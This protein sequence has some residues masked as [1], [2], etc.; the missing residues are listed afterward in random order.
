MCKWKLVIVHRSY[1]LHGGGGHR[2]SGL[3]C[4]TPVKSFNWQSSHDIISG[5]S[6]CV[7]MINDV[8]RH[9]TPIILKRVTRWHVTCLQHVTSPQWV[10]WVQPVTWLQHGTWQF[11]REKDRIL[12]IGDVLLEDVTLPTALGLLRSCGSVAELIIRRR[13]YV[14][15]PHSRQCKSVEINQTR[16]GRQGKTTPRFLYRVSHI[17]RSLAQTPQRWLSI[18]DG[19]KRA[20]AVIMSWCVN[21]E[22]TREK[23]QERLKSDLGLQFLA[24][25]QEKTTNRRKG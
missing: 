24:D 25:Q 18:N 6:P 2:I 3:D 16:K 4:L 10:T 22:R 23:S 12:S 15:S 20:S 9:C 7:C 21:K 19:I 14:P 13:L 8:I 1:L 5:P 11:C 17:W